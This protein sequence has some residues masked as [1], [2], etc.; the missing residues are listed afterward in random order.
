VGLSEGVDAVS[1]AQVVLEVVQPMDEVPGGGPGLDV[2][3]LVQ[4][5]DAD[6]VEPA[7]TREPRLRSPAGSREGLTV[8]LPSWDVYD[9]RTLRNCPIA[10]AAARSW[11]MTSPTRGEPGARGRSGSRALTTVERIKLVEQL[12]GDEKARRRDLPDL[13]FFMLAT[14]ARIGEP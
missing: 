10:T 5:G 7:R 8:L 4:C 11:P 6:L 14:G 2:S 12:Q 13:V 9:R 1:V 3:A